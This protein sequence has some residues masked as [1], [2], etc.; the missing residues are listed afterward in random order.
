MEHIID[1]KGKS[2][3]RVASEAAKILM[4]KNSPAYARHKFSGERVSILHASDVKIDSKRLKGKIFTRYSGYPG[5]FKKESL[6]A[7]S[8]RRGYRELFRVAVYGMLPDNKL[9]ALMIKN[10]KVTE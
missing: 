7:L 9:R 6:E 5:G 8:A 1:A 2:L 4:G 10:L 3:G